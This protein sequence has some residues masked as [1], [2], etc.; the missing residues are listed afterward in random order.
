[1]SNTRR[2]F[3]AYLTAGI[4]G[5]AAIALLLVH[6]ADRG[7]LTLLML[8]SGAGGVLVWAAA[9]GRRQRL[10]L[11]E[12]LLE[13]VGD[14][15]ALADAEGRVL[16]QSPSVAR[17]MGHPAGERV[18]LSA[19]D[20]VHPEDAAEAQRA[21]AIVLRKPGGAWSFRHR[22][23]R[24]GGAWRVL[25]TQ[26]KNLL[27]LPA[28][29]GI[30]ISSRDV[31]DRVRAEVRQATQ[32]AVTRVLNEASSVA[33]AGPPIL[34]AICRCAGWDLGEVW[35][36]DGDVLRWK[37]SWHIPGVNGSAFEAVSREATFA[38]GTGLPGRV[39]ETG[40]PAW[41]VDVAEDPEFVRRTAAQSEGL[42]GAIAFPILRGGSAC[43]VLVFYSHELREP[44]LVLLDLM[45]D[46]GMKIGQFVEG[47]QAEAAL[48]DSEERFC[49]L[50]EATTEGVVIHDQGVVLD[51]NASIS[52]M[53]GYAR[54]ELLGRNGLTLVSP[55][56]RALLAHRL[57]EGIEGRAE[58]VAL[59]KDGSQFP[60]EIDSRAITYQGRL[61]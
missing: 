5:A 11:T 9:A 27:D 38:R 10:A 44:D 21:L 57:A 49:R 43:G 6:G 4:C 14:Y 30:V 34:E 17:Q 23:R 18:G 31:T 45:G 59:R 19:L 48:R 25:D 52:R 60:A 36:A 46:V 15:I 1:M 54:E 22:V 20:L 24:K 37:G 61:A 42:H 39:W 16:Y 41:M 13:N 58:I 29:R 50:S 12:A 56:S 33:E 28:V 32:L 40:Q 3:I 2:R 55:E 53:S 7:H 26:A 51:L 8:G 35:C 47:K